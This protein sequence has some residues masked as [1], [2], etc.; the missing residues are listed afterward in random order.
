MQAVIMAGGKGTRLTSITKDEIPKPM[1]PVC[2]KPLLLWQIDELKKNGISDIVMIIGHL[3]HKIEEY[4]GD[5]QAFGVHISYIRE[6]MPLGTA[7]A[8]YYLKELIREQYFLLVFG[9]VYF[10]ID[11]ERM[12]K[13]HLNKNSCATLFVHPNSHPVDSDLVVLDSQDKIVHFDSKNNVRDYWYDNCVNAGFYI[14]DKSVCDYVAA[15]EKLDLEK[16]IL[17]KM[18][19]SGKDIYGYRSPEYIK[20]CGTVERI[21]QTQKDISNGFIEQKCLKNKQKCIFLDRDGT[22]NQFKGLV[23]KEDDF[24]LE[25]SASDAIKAINQ[26]GWLGIIVTNQPSVAR[27]LCDVEDIELIHKKMTT[28]LGQNGVYLDDILFCPHH[29]DKG[30]PEENPDYKIVCSCRKPKTGMIESAAEKYNIDIA[31][32]WMIGDTTVDI[33]TGKNA[34]L[35]TALVLTGEKG[36]DGKFSVQADIT[37]E[38]VFEAVK[39]I[40]DLEVNQ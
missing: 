28:L 22:I 12:E 9:D 2:G 29:P 14:L 33:Q 36:Q 5:G 27:G 19:A 10:S 17:M 34:G 6:E 18:V 20:D 38:N 8:F 40:L 4:F 31:Q 7:G 35:K 32:S 15:P 21:T 13:F 16:D 39:K 26:S 3:G 23:W 30:Y 25:E 37:C 24:I 1:V 11:I